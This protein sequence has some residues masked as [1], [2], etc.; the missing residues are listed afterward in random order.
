MGSPRVNGQ[1][2]EKRQIKEHTYLCT[3]GCCNEFMKIVTLE[4]WFQ[5]ENDTFRFPML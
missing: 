3:K 1:G 5:F 2:T 4:H